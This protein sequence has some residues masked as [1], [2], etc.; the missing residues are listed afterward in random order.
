MPASPTLTLGRVAK[1]WWPLALSWLLMGLEVPA[2]SAVVA[3][4]IEP[5][6]NLAAFGGVV[7]PLALLIESPIVMLL[8]ASTALS[9]DRAAYLKIRRFMLW[10]S[11]ALTLIHAAIV[12][13]PLYGVV[14]GSL[15]DPPAEVVGPA[16]VG[17]AIMIPWTW[18]IAYRRFNQ[19]VLIRFGHSG[20][21]G[22]GTL[23]RLAAD[24]AV[25]TVGYVVGSIPGI[26]VAAVAMNAGVFSEAFYVKRRVTPV[27]RDQLPDSAPGASWLGLRA[28]LAFYIPLSLTSVIALFASPLGSAALSRMPNALD[29]LAL[30]PVVTGVSFVFRSFGFAFNEVVVALLDERGSFPALRRFAFLGAA[31]TSVGLMAFLVPPVGDFWFHDVIGL[32]QGLAEVARTSLWFALPLPALSMLQSWLQGMVVHSRRTRLITEAVA[33]SLFSMCSVLVAGVLGGGVVGLYVGVAA[34][35]VGDSIRTGLLAW[36]GRGV[37]RVLAEDADS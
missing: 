33:L 22:T 13:T 26:V 27:L 30:W 24:A 28:F 23:I 9:K 31:A 37:W 2:V 36:R 6:V 10:I 17:L 11:A 15:I 8:A 1:T 20:A 25:L 4:L 35:T 14:V 18:G 12:F 7:F 16:R 32:P 3:R 5:K 34:L 29:S 19:G 21:V